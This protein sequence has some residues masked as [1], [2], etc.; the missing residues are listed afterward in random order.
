MEDILKENERLDDL[1]FEDLRIIQNKNGFCFGIDSILLSDF[2]KDIKAGSK[3]VDIGS[4]TGILSILLARKSKASK[5]YGVEVQ[6]DV[7]EMSQR[8]VRLNNLEDKI[9]IINKNI[10]DIFEVLPK[11]EIDVIVTNPPYMKLG[12]GAQ[13]EENSK[14]IARH[15][16]ECNLEDIIAISQKMLKPN[17]ELYMVNRVD[18]MIDIFSLM[19]A[20]KIEPKIVRFIS[21]YVGK[22]PN[23][24]LIKAVKGAGEEIKVL[25]PLI[26]YNEDGTYTKEIFK[27]YNMELE[28]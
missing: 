18:R 1:G 19:R 2:A 25:D 17:G 4:G 26:I 23:L 15:E 14:L 16:V 12:T 11:N 24:L 5:F 28:K 3:V 8:S 20:Y 6:E 7:A 10:K 21:P 27:I 9:E 13:N 22:A